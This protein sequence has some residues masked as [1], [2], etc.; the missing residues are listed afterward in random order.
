MA[1]YKKNNATKKKKAGMKKT[2]W[3][4]R[5]FSAKDLAIKAIKNANR[6]RKL[7]NVERK[8]FD[9][10]SSAM[11]VDTGSVIALS[12]I[13]QGDSDGDRDGFSL[14]TQGLLARLWMT[15]NNNDNATV[16][17]ILFFV[18]NQQVGDTAPSITDVLE[19][20]AP[21]APLNNA[22]VGRFR[23]L[24]DDVY[25]LN[26]Q[27]SGTGVEKFAKMYFPINH[28]IRFNGTAGTDIQKGGVYMGVLSNNASPNG[29]NLNYYCRLTYTDN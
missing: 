10:S 23:I 26:N 15:G 28:H 19:S 18:D 6:I 21:T 8:K 25:A 14:L 9:S 11:V 20:S 29:P 2:A 4:E 12:N 27:V 5:K 7:I 3:Y 13:A 1:G 22:T 16:L 24:S 17:R